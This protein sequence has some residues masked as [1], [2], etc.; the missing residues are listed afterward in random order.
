[1]TSTCK[2]IDCFAIVGV[3]RDAVYAKPM[4]PNS[5]SVVFPSLACVVA[6][7]LW[8]VLW[9]P[10]RVLQDHG[11]PGLWSTLLIYIV[12]VLFI[13]KPCWQLRECYLRKKKEYLLLALAAGWTNLAFILALLEGEVV[14]VLL[15]FYLSPVWAIIMARFV[16]DE[17]LARA[18][19]YALL[20]A[21]S[22]AVIMLWDPDFFSKPLNL[23]D[24]FAITSGMAFAMTNILVRKIG[25]VHWSLKLGSAWVGVI[26]LCCAGL[27]VNPSSLP[28]LTPFTITLISI[29]GFPFMFIMTW[30]AQY[31][32]TRL[33][34]QSSSII[35][36]LEI[37]AGAVSAALLTNEVV[38][39]T[40]YVG[41]MLIVLAGLLGV[42]NKQAG[43]V[44]T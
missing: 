16:L 29:L 20:L 28:I 23:A 27:L 18:G 14:R 37:I 35:F 19:L 21:I 5:S 24:L 4:P 1:M 7:I 17:K 31:G 43:V 22:G 40:E 30:S 12:A 26:F 2:E 9:Y 34:I 41:G 33:P 6:A 8:G 36:L 3:T 38:S 32:V 25:E 13:I 42:S 44:N 39:I 10:L 11:I 15:L